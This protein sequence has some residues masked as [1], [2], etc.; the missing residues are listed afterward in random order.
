MAVGWSIMSCRFI[1]ECLWGY[2]RAYRLL[3]LYY[4]DVWKLKIFNQGWPER[5]IVAEIR[6]PIAGVYMQLY[7]YLFMLVEEPTPAAAA[8]IKPQTPNAM[9]VSITLPTLTL[10][11]LDHRPWYSY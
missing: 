8:A 4:Y 1:R 3:G 10:P 2:L 7:V 9:K 11:A 5:F 6:D